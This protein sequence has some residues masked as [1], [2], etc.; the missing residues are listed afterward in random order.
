MWIDRIRGGYNTNKLARWRSRAG[1][2]GN[3]G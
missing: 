1:Y 3:P 2:L